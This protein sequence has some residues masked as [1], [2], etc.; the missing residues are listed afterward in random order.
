MAVEIPIEQ[1]TKY[2]RARVIGARALQISQGAPMAVK[3]SKK[4]LEEIKY[5][6]V[7]IAKR[8]YDEGV[9]PIGVKRVL[10]SER[11]PAKKK[12]E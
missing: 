10:P 9:I 6:P 3:L 4:D 5:N 8:E 11:N 7:E 12:K 1:Y 2:E